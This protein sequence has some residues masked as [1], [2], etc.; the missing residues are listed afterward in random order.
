[1][2]KACGGYDMENLD[3]D[4]DERL[5]RYSNEIKK[6]KIVYV[7]GRVRY[8]NRE[9]IDQFKS[10]NNRDKSEN[11]NDNMQQNNYELECKSCSSFKYIINIIIKLIFTCIILISTPFIAAS[12][13]SMGINGFISG[14]GTILTVYFLINFIWIFLE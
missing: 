13:N 5:K 2:N 1:M 8:V 6:M 12:I 4:F 14:V 10:I 11:Q 7:D 9:S 3:K